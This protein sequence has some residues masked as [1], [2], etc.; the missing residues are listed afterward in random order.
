VLRQKGDD[1]PTWRLPELS[2]EM[3]VIASR[4]SRLF[5]FDKAD[6]GFEPPP[7]V[8]TIATMHRAKGLEW[9]R[10]YLLSVNNYDFPS[11][12]PNDTYIAEKWFIRDSLN[13]Q[14]EALAQLEGLADPYLGYEEGRATL[15]ARQD[16]VRER[17]RLLYVGITRARKD[18]VITWN[19]GKR[20]VPCQP[21]IP[22]IALQ[23]YVKEGA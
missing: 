13:L 7:G 22:L 1:N 3:L 5:G 19:T 9:D 11:E 23:T 21:A 12:M 4:Q 14:A 2:G 8:V 17:L 20:K 18:L 6:T 10:V 16:Y 15:Q